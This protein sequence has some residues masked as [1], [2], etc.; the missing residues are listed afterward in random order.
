MFIQRLNIKPKFLKIQDSPP[1]I[2]STYCATILNFEQR[3]DGYFL[4]TKIALHNFRLCM[5]KCMHK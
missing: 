3:Y 4:R 1:K 5:G 2:F